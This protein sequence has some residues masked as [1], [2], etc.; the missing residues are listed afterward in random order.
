MTDKQHFV[1][2]FTDFDGVEAVITKF[3]DEGFSWPVVLFNVVQVLEKQ[4]GYEIAPDVTVKGTCLEELRED[5]YAF[6]QP[7]EKLRKSGE[8]LEL[9]PETSAGLTD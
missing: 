5:P 9:F 3:S 2:G 1:F 6:I 8:Q 7:L 4:F